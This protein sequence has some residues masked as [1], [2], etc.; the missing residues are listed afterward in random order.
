[1]VFEP[2][3]GST[4]SIK[5]CRT[6]SSVFFEY[7]SHCLDLETSLYGCAC[8]LSRVRLFATQWA[9]AHQTPLSMEFSRQES[10]SRLPFTT[11]RDLPDPG[12]EPTSPALAGRFFTTG[13]TWEAPVW[14]DMWFNKYRKM[15]IAEFR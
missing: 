5:S 3:L 13:A 6:P 9:A 7:L 15:L 12:I 11:P 1:M 2:W 8:V 4:S 14:I 10:W